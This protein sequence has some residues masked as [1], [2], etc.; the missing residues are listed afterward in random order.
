MRIT[1]NNAVSLRREEPVQDPQDS[2]IRLGTRMP[3]VILNF[4]AAQGRE[5]RTRLSQRMLLFLGVLYLIVYILPLG[6][7]PLILPDETRYFEIPREMIATGDWVV[8]RLDGFN[9]FEKPVMGYWVNAV[10][11]LVFGQNAFAVRFPS[12]LAAGIMALALLLALRRFND[13]KT[14]WLAAVI[15]L[16]SIQIFA[17]GTYGVL[18]SVFSMFL[19]TGLLAFYRGFQANQPGLRNRWLLLAGSLFGAAFLTKGFIALAVPGLIIAAFAV[20][21][22]RLPALLRA[23]WL[24]VGAALAVILPWALAIHLREGDFWHYFFWVEHI[25]RF[26]HPGKG[27]HPE[28]FW[29]FVPVIVTGLLPWSALLPA[30]VPGLRNTFTDPLIR[31][32]TCWL[33]AAFLFFSASSGKLTTYILPCF[34][35]AAALMAVGLWRSLTGGRQRAYRMGARLWSGLLLLASVG[36][37]LEQTTGILGQRPYGPAETWKWMLACVGLAV[38][39]AAS[40]WSTL[41]SQ[42]L[43]KLHGFALAGTFFFAVS[44]FIFPNS[45]YA[46]KA[47]EVLLMRNKQF[48]TPESVVV[49]DGYLIR[50]A[51]AHLKRQDIRLFA[52]K[53]EL[54]YGIRHAPPEKRRVLDGEALARLV[55]NSEQAHVPV[56][57]IMRED[58]RSRYQALLPVPKR[59]DVYGNFAFM[60]F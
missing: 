38:W 12:A 1:A 9:Y 54:D 44:V 45:I 6:H 42:P 16:S 18:D 10:S 14:A 46:K 58:R 21:E 4:P 23:S 56:A 49:A 31:F 55:A 39:G 11:M 50:S 27:Q 17:I 48:V 32:L 15:F 36:L 37:A 30:A 35:P 34:P 43:R 26:L 19:T 3:P 29:F 24:P 8:P 47:P 2:D 25:Q 20:W 33:A 59:L 28:A 22:G 57:V 13:G 40:L 41:G 53:D 52:T 7:R 51:C 5:Y 60:L